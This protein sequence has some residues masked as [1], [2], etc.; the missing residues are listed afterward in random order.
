MNHTKCIQ[1]RAADFRVL[2]FDKC[3]QLFGEFYKDFS[4]L[5]LAKFCS[6]NFHVFNK[7][8]RMYSKFDKYSN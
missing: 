1:K 2:K 3:R 5:F 4:R 8:D 6:G 7:A